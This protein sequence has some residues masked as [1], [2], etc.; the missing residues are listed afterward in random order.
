MQRHV[1]EILDAS[2]GRIAVPAVKRDGPR[3]RLGGIE[4]H[5]HAAQRPQPL[6]GLTEM[7]SSGAARSTLTSGSIGS[8][9]PAKGAG[10]RVVKIGLCRGLTGV[11]KR[12]VCG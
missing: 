6:L 2:G 4:R 10:F 1:E 9:G 3:E 5:T 11:G 7:P 8:G 12:S